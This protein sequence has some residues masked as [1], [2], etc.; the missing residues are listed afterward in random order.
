MRISAS[1]ALRHAWFQD[2]PQLQGR[3]IQPGQAPVQHVQQIPQQQ[4]P[5]YGAQ[6]PGGV[7]Y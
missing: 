3:A 1:E 2:L 6:V 5:M 7:G 4:Q